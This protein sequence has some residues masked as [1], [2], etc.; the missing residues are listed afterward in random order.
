MPQADAQKGSAHV[1]LEERVSR[2]RIFWT[3]LI[4]STLP[5]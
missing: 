1:R 5:S 2:L 4:F 3:R